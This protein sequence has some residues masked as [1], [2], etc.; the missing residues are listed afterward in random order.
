MTQMDLKG[1]ML[2]EESQSQNATYCIIPFIQ[3]SEMTRSQRW[4]DE[5]GL[6]VGDSMRSHVGGIILHLDHNGYEKP[7][8]IT[9]HRPGYTQLVKSQ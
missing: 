5:W 6:R 3:H 8:V 2:S 4:R 7:H 9:L 1:I